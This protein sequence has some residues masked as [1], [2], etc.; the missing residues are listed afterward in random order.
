MVAV[1]LA[2][3]SGGQESAT[4]ERPATAA[5]GPEQGAAGPAAPPAETGG[6][7][8]SCD[9]RA[10]EMGRLMRAK[11]DQPPMIM[12]SG[13]GMPVLPETR[14]GEVVRVPGYVLTMDARGGLELEGD[15][16]TRPEEI[17]ERI[18]RPRY[19]G[20]ERNVMYLWADREARVAAVVDAIAAL[21]PGLERRLVVLD[22]TPPPQPAV[23]LLQSAGVRKL[24]ADL[25][26]G[27][28]NPSERATVLAKAL[29][30]AVAPCAP[31]VRAFGDV[32]GEEDKG[33]FLAREVPAALRACNCAM[34]DVDVVEYGVLAM[35]GVYDR[36]PRALPLPAEAEL[37]KHG[38]RTVGEL[39]AV[40]A[41]R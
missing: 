41:G 6:T 33:G 15:R 17:K 19:R 29:Q 23:R 9:Q 34:V 16:I 27:V 24:Q 5:P 26:P 12:S 11:A 25:R 35:F 30:G 28:V 18:E 10:D 8:P 38:Q 36:W 13:P 7:A 22:P 2:G 20:V 4:K 14:A 37:R 21:P 40:L 3:C 1:V 31:M 39:V 32:V